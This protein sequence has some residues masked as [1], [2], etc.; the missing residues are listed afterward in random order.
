MIGYEG[1]NNC[2]YL[3]EFHTAI[4]P[5]AGKNCPSYVPAYLSLTSNFSSTPIANGKEDKKRGKV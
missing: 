5:R 3:P 4:I 2:E 1:M